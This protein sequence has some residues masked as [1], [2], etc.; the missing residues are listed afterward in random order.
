MKKTT[1]FQKNNLSLKK[2]C[3][4]HSRTEK[5]RSNKKI[6]TKETKLKS[7]KLL[8][9]E[10]RKKAMKKKLFT[11]LLLVSAVV[12]A[13]E[14][15][16]FTESDFN[17]VRTT[18]NWFS[19]ER[20]SLN[21]EAGSTVYIMNYISNY[22]KIY[23]LDDE[24]YIVYNESL[25]RYEKPG[26]DMS[27]GKYGYLTVSTDA[28][29]NYTKTFHEG[30]GA[31]EYFSYSDSQGH[32]VTTKGYLLDTFNENTEIFFVM[33]PVSNGDPVATVNSYDLVGAPDQPYLTSRQ[34]NTK[35]ILDQIRVNFGTSE[36][37]GHEFVVGYVSSDTPAPSGQPLPG[38]LTSCLVGLAAT[39]LAA[40]R[41]KQSRK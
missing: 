26:F 25:D 23:N 9:S 15:T 38:V 33:T 37:V 21:V 39:G 7:K 34:N 22:N 11:L 3:V 5:I 29:G 10:K 20:I 14:Y 16:Q 41:R 8:V 13:A 31:Y 19:A 18:Q 17:V 27:P 35:D 30:N 4:K 36:S 6:K 12:F 40:R 24:N 32:T 28:N 1:F 2:S